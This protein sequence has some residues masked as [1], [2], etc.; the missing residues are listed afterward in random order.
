[1]IV[2]NEEDTIERCLNSV[3]DIVDE[4][5]IVD[6]GSTDKTLEKLK[7]YNIEPYNF[8]WID[9][10]SK[11]RNYSFSKASKEY[12]LWLDAGDAVPKEDLCKLKILKNE[13]NSNVDS[14]TMDYVVEFDENN[15]TVNYLKVNRLIKREKAFEWVGRVHESLIVWGNI[16]NEDIK[17]HHLKHKNVTDR[18]LKIYENMIKENIKFTAREKFYY[19]NELFE[20]NK[21]N[22]AI[23]MYLEFIECNEGWIEHV[24]NAC[25]SLADCYKKKNDRENE[26]KYIFKAFEYDAPR[27][28]FCCRLGDK[29]LEDNNIKSAIFWYKLAV[30]TKPKEDTTV[31]VNHS[32]YTWV[33]YLKLSICYAK[34]D[35]YDIAMEYNEIAAQYNPNNMQILN[36]REYLRSKLNMV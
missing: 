31:L 13:L 25:A 7:K 3:K 36:N 24:K 6:T 10:F 35:R 2:K 28:D 11:A 15:D 20:N 18:N 19:A 27:P 33:P 22:E 8:N 5:V 1:M 29:F 32:M 21:C 14:V 34:L 9:D 16:I 12:I 26:L 23:K 17:I 4:F 30:Q